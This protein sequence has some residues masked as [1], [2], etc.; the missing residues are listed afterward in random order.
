MDRGELAVDTQQRGRP[1]GE[2]EVRR[3]VERENGE[4]LLDAG[5]VDRSGG[6]GA[7]LAASSLG[8]L[9]RAERG[10]ID[11]PGGP[12]PAFGHI[13]PSQIHMRPVRF[14]SFRS[15]FTEWLG[16]ASNISEPRNKDR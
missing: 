1:G 3:V 16:S 7:I 13:R 4:V 5:D 6:H 15:V 14:V 11:G 12:F 10:E 9:T 2:M 8:V